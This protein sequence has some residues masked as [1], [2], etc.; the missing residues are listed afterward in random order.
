MIREFVEELAEMIRKDTGKVGSDSN[1]NGSNVVEAEGR[2]F[3]A[4]LE[5]PK[6]RRSPDIEKQIG[7]LTR[8]ETSLELR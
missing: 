3:V 8:F 7:T 4:S 5:T 6:G 2:A 1:A